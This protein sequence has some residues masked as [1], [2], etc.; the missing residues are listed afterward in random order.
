MAKTKKTNVQIR[1][2]QARTTWTRF[3]L[4]REQR[5][6]QWPAEYPDADLGPLA[7]VPG[8]MTVRLGRMVE[9]PEKAALVV[10]KYSRR[11]SASH[12]LTK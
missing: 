8:R 9:D 5:W 7:N 11:S 4:P 10:R 6:I 12:V 2:E 3:R 1:Q